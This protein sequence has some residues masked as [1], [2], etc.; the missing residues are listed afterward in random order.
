MSKPKHPPGEPMTLGNMRAL[1]V[2]RLIASCLKDACRHQG[3]IYVSKYPD[4]T[5]VPSFTEM[6]VCAVWYWRCDYW[7]PR[8]RPGPGGILPLLA[9][10]N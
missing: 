6:V 1:G 2:Q 5:E 4:D 8:R 9:A 10:P 3:L 7:P